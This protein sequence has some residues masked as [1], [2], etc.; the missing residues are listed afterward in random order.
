[1][2]THTARQNYQVSESIDESGEVQGIMD[3][4]SHIFVQY[5]KRYYFSDDASQNKFVAAFNHF[6]AINTRDTH[7]SYSHN[8]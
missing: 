5:M 2:V 3:V 1:M 7:Q 6:V 4:A 8:F